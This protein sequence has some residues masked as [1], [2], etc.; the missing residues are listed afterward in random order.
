MQDPLI[1]L[2]SSGPSC[3]GKGAPH[4]LAPLLCPG[5]SRSPTPEYALSLSIEAPLHPWGNLS[6]RGQWLIS[7]PLPDPRSS[8][9]PVG[10]NAE[11]CL[12]PPEVGPCRARIPSFYYSRY[13]QS[14]R[15]F[16]YGGCEGNANNFET[17]EA[18]EE[19]CWRIESK[20]WLRRLQ[21]EQ[22]APGP[23]VC[24]GARTGALRDRGGRARIAGWRSSQVCDALSASSLAWIIIP[25]LA[26]T[27]GKMPSQGNPL[28]GCNVLGA[29]TTYVRALLHLS[30]L[31]HPM[32]FKPPGEHHFLLSIAHR[33]ETLS[34]GFIPEL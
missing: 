6:S 1:P 3:R 31:L 26:Q 11:I 16:M 22:R 17:R 34:E 30:F 8:L 9:P 10:N 4:R 24:G 5:P 21:Q 7:F 13:T 18:C 27:Q 23:I 14:C 2:A 33:P 20:W 12:L 19:A 29:T 32:V 25:C 15:Q 28:Q